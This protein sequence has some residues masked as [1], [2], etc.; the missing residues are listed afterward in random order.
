MNDGEPQVYLDPDA[1]TAAALFARDIRGAVAMLN[2]LRFRDVADYSEFPELAPRSQISG[3]LAYE[4]YIE[5]TL[6]FLRA[7]GGEV[8]YLGTG[9]DYL[10]GP[11]GEGWDMALLVRQSSVA[12]FMAF[13][14]D[15]AYLAG[16]G[17]RVAAVRD[18][19]LLPLV[20]E[21]ASTIE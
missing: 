9:G 10:I 11:P 8:L 12:A 3:R 13:A 5:H 7:S 16:I 14:S 1:A 21:P 6:P 4:R 17:H 19:R 2:L 18:S 15:P 20:D